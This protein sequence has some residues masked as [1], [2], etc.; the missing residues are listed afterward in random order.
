MTVAL[1]VAPFKVT[2]VGTW[3]DVELDPKKP[4]LANCSM[5]KAKQTGLLGYGTVGI[6]VG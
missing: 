5:G 6:D 2:V 4:L 3:F 1:W